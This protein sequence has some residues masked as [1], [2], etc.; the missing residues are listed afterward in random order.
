M[1]STN[2]RF[3]AYSQRIEGRNWVA[4]N[5]RSAYEKNAR[6]LKA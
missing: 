6:R 3:S 2:P 5:V 4:E 1:K